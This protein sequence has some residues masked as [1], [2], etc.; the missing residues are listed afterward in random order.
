VRLAPKVSIAALAVTA[1]LLIGPLLVRPTT[2]GTLSITDA[3]D[4]AAEFVDIVGLR[5]HV[6]HA[7]YTGRDRSAPLF[8]LLHGFGASSFTWRDLLAPLSAHGDV[9]AY[10]RPGF[11]FTERPDTWTGENRT[12]PRATC[13]CSPHSSRA[14]A[15]AAM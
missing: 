7:A 11:G 15:T 14:R 3:A 4:P 6:E 1:T 12:E 9:L 8:V 13:G 5:V 2:R 10:D